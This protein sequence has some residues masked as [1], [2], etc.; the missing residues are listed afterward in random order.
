MPRL[1]RQPC[2]VHGSQ[3]TDREI[4]ERLH[5][6]VYCKKSLSLLRAWGRNW[7]I[8]TIFLIK[9]L[10]S[11]FGA[12]RKWTGRQSSLLQSKMTLAV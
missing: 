6:C 8:T 1:C 12:K 10:M 3:R 11:P 7:P 9:D 5:G 4:C 2:A